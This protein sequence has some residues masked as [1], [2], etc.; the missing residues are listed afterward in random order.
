LGAEK[1]TKVKEIENY[2]FLEIDFLHLGTKY[3]Y[4]FF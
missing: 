1:E 4:L 2:K 3:F